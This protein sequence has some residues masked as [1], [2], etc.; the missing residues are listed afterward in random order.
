MYKAKVG[1]IG[2]GNIGTNLLMKIARSELLECTIF[3]GKNP[4]SPNIIR[5]GEMGINVS[6]AGIQALLEQQDQIDIIMDATSAQSHINNKELFESMGKYMINLTPTNGEL[7]CVPCINWD[8]AIHCREVNMITCGGQ[9][10]IPL[11]YAIMQTGC[12]VTY[13]ETVST[14][15]AKSAG[16]ATRENIDEFIETTSGAMRRFTGVEKTKAIMIINSNE[17]P[18]NMRNTI[19]MRLKKGDMSAICEAVSKMESRVAKY[20]PGYRIVLQ[21]AMVDDILAITL[22]VSGSGDFLPEYAGNL[23]IIT[24][25]AVEMAEKYCNKVLRKG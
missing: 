15:S 8:E 24:C 9:A 12:E 17:P 21:P 23:D 22:E 16:Q 3:A 25:A 20:V 13:I 7:G 14:I 18:V 5:A 1:I 4:N 10:T 6:G 2:T 11:A 19:Y